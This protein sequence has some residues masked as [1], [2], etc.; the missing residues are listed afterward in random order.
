MKATQK[1]TIS[2]PNFQTVAFRIEGTAP[3]MIHHFGE[4]AR[5]QMM[6]KQTAKEKVR[7]PRQ[8]KDYEAEFN[9]ARYLSAKGWDGFYA[10]S[11]RNAMIS[12]ARY[13]DG[14]QMT[15][16]KGLF[17]VQADGNDKTDGTPLVKIQGCKAIHDTRPARNDDKGADIRN[18][19]RFDN[20]YA[21]IRIDFDADAMTA[22]DVGNLLH[23]AGAQVGIGD[24][25]PGSP[26]SN[27]MG[28]GTFS[29]TGSKKGK[30]K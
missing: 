6:D 13:V 18:R 21:D 27:G 3:L 4:K 1:I 15:K 10:G 12:A 8:P 14:L 16:S 24:G 2:E 11:I 29:V 28:F 7:G 22:Q 17:F 19:P 25:R 9:S 23:R 26:N 30:G 20:W 5:K